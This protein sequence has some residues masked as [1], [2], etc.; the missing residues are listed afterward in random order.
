VLFAIPVLG[1]K[2]KFGN[3]LTSAKTGKI[4]EKIVQLTYFTTK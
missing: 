4:T 3:M 2:D 1:K